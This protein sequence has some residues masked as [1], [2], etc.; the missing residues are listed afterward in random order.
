MPISL[1][2]LISHREGTLPSLLQIIGGSLFIALCAQISI[3]LPFTPVPITGQTFAV[4]LV[5]GLLG[6]TK[7]ALS[8]LAYLAETTLGLP[9]LAGGLSMPLAI[10]GLTG[11]YL[12]G[13]VIQAGM[14][15]WFAK[16]NQQ[17]SKRRLLLGGLAAIVIQMAIGATWLGHFIGYENAMAMGVYPFIPGELIKLLAVTAIIYSIKHVDDAKLTMK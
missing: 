12:I 3:P 17:F 6:R 15:G 11:G 1:V 14:M 16:R 7:G 4:L 13:M 9:F 10:V 5:G 2:Q 8:V